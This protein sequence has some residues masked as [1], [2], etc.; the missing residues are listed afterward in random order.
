MKKKILLLIIMLLTSLS[1]VKAL[2]VEDVKITNYANDYSNV[3]S[4]EVKEYI[5]DKGKQLEEK[6]G[7]QIVV[8]TIP[9]LEGDSL[10][11]FAND[12]FNYVGIGNKEQNNG[13]LILLV[14]KDR[15]LRVEVG[16]GLEGCLNDGK[17]GRYEDAYMMDY[18]R[19]SNWNDAIKNGYDAFFNEIVKEYGLDLETADL[20]EL[21]YVNEGL[22]PGLIIFI[23]SMMFF[24][25]IVIGSVRSAH[26]FGIIDIIIMALAF[27]PALILK[28]IGLGE[29]AEVAAYGG[30]FF[31]MIFL[32]ARSGRSGRGHGGGYWS[33]GGSSW[34]S[35]GGG[36]SGGGGH[37]S[38]G[39]ASRSF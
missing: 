16:D 17:V 7:A 5:N 9:S 37:S 35:S 3:L 32:S 26:R 19:D 33:S 11:T 27:L 24:G 12:L 30:F 20:P 39:G 34:S 10:E 1:I 18:L 25:P 38:G 23:I 4:D 13:L 2:K 28:I 8:V 31:V 14:T 22:S 21:S 29:L 36:F 6:N 15:K